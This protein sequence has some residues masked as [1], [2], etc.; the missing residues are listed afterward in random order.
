MQDFNYLALIWC[1]VF[2][3]YYLANKTHLTPLLF[4]LVM[5]SIM[6]TFGLLP[7]QAT[8][9]IA[10]LSEF[11]I[12]LIMFALGFE[13]N[14]TI[15][16]RSIKRTWGIALFG[17][18]VPFWASYFCAIYFWHDTNIAILVGLA[19]AA[20]TVS[21]SMAVLK[22]E[23]LHLTKAATGIMT[24]AILDNAASLVFVAI[25]IPLVSGQSE[26]TIAGILLT[27]CKAL[28]FF[29]VVLI[30]GLWIFPRPETHSYGWLRTLLTP[31][32][33][34]NVLAFSDGKVSTL[35][36][37]TIA[38]IFAIMAHHFGLHPA[39]GAYMAGLIMHK[40]YFYRVDKKDT[41]STYKKTRKIIDDVAFAWIG[42]IFFVNLG[43]KIVLDGEIL[44][45][46]VDTTLVLTLAIMVAQ[47]LSAGIAARVTGSFNFKESV[48]I[49]FGMLGRAELTFVVMDIGYVHND[50][51][52]TEVFYTLM[53]TAFALNISVPLFIKLWHHYYSSEKK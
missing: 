13:E 2:V 31:F 36:I 4:Y 48:M 49:G 45:S 41:V 3:S 38:V 18:L 32:G 15:F 5:G 12:I 50:I 37:L 53:F 39:V 8:P 19:M 29:A 28:L 21:L 51:F 17:A 27:S 14:P 10:V 34:H 40:E 52:T 11:G 24:A 6:V 42:P 30:F 1:S 44:L 23:N 22:H 33:L 46:I 43:A 26:L 7:E 9:F 35:A 16:M 47:I 25:L 20:T